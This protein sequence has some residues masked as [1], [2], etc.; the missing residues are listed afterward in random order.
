MPSFHT[1]LLR[2]CALIYHVPRGPYTIPV[3][4]EMAVREI[5]LIGSAQA[6]GRNPSYTGIRDLA[7]VGHLPEGIVI[8]VRGTQPPQ[9]TSLGDE[10]SI[11]LDWTN[12]GLVLGIESFDFGGVVHQGFANA[13]R[14]LCSDLAD[15][16]VISR[17]RAMV[18]A[19]A[20]TTRIILTGHSKGG[21]VAQL[22]AFL[23]RRESALAGATI[24]VV[25]FAAARPGDTEFA[26]LFKA[27]GIGCLRYESHYD[28]VPKLPLG[29]PPD[30]ALTGILHV[31]GIEPPGSG[32]GFV[33][34]GHL[35][36]ESQAEADDWQGPATAFP[37]NLVDA[38]TGTPLGELYRAIAAHEIKPGSHYERLVIS[39]GEQ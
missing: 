13:A 6:I 29:G 11:G 32:A 26:A 28:V 24:D 27:T 35:I 5:G 21:P 7:L 30:A 23:L 3:N 38:F 39:H 15:E 19:N 8:A 33:S 37:H 9:I 16:G 2:L 1:R 18:G 25:T 31:V 12:D 36:A 22:I 34:V 14:S 4:A 10:L 20:D 17:V